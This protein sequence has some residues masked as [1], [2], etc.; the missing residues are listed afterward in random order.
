M[1]YLHGGP[2]WS[3]RRSPSMR[4]EWIE[5]METVYLCLDGESPSMRREWIE[6]A[7]RGAGNTTVESPS[8]RREWIEILVCAAM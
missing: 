4:R 1:K 2:F 7:D 5:I 8:M 6:M 3:V